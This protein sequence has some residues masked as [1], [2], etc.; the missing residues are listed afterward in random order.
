[1]HF[2][3]NRSQDCVNFHLLTA[4]VTNGDIPEKHFTAK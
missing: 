3:P 4:L 1:M 2:L